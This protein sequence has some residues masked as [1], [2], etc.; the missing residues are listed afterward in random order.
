[1]QSKTYKL[2]HF[3]TRNS[4]YPQNWWNPNIEGK[5]KA[6]SSVNKKSSSICLQS[7]VLH[8]SYIYIKMSLRIA[9]L[10]HLYLSSQIVICSKNKIYMCYLNANISYNY[11]ASKAQ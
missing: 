7:K 8:Y 5:L 3:N 11:Y 9:S 10:K 2:T 4:K 6:E 1:M